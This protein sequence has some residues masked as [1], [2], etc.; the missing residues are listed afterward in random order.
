MAEEEGCCSGKVS[1]MKA[2]AIIMTE[3]SRHEPST[4]L[5]YRDV[6]HRSRHE[7]TS[8]VRVNTTH[9][10]L[11][12]IAGVNA[13]YPRYPYFQGWWERVLGTRG[14]TPSL[15]LGSSSTIAEIK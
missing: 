1:L 9:L 2:G 12:M 3:R 11:S 6:S 4:Q 15:Y 7:Q 10:S 14:H 5:W 13:R 8:N